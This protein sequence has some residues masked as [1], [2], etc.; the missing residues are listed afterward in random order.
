[1]DFKR[2]IIVIVILIS[3][4]GYSLAC[5]CDGENTVAGSFRNSSLVIYGNVLSMRLISFAET[6]RKSKADMV[7]KK[8]NSQRIQL[9]D[10]ELIYEVN[11]EV[12]EILKG[13]EK[14]EVITVY[15]P[16]MNA[17]CGYSFEKSKGYILYASKI[18]PHYSLFVSGSDNLNDLEK[19]NTFWT[20]QCTRTA[21][22]SKG[23]LEALR[24]LRK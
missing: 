16:R 13:I 19:E 21:E 1:M 2:I 12:I 6:M 8:L 17:S 18:S 22:Y 20:N 10:G 7:R 23:E 15:T 11:F 9:F 14:K 5:T 3:F 24:I 4:N